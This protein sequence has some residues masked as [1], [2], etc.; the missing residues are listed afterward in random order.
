MAEAETEQAQVAAGGVATLVAV[1][2]DLLALAGAVVAALLPGTTARANCLSEICHGSPQKTVCE[3]LL[4]V[5]SLR[6]AL[7]SIHEKT[8]IVLA[9]LALSHLPIVRAHSPRSPL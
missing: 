6:T 1:G 4:T 8:R 3:E 9:A 5:S 2:K 7:L